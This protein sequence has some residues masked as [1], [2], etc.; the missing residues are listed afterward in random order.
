MHKVRNKNVPHVFLKVSGLLCH[1]YPTNF[2]LINFSVLQTF[3]KTT[4]FA[5]SLEVHFFGTIPSQK[6]KKNLIT[7]YSLRKAKEKIMKL[8][9]ASNFFQ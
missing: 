4:R 1:A 3:L 9:T 2:P 8:S 5:I 7:F 6:A